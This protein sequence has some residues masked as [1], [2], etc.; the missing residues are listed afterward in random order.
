MWKI[1]TFCLHL[2]LFGSILKVYF[3]STLVSGLHPQLTLREQGLEPPADRIVVF[4]VDGLRA[5][6]FFAKNCTYFPH[7][8]KLFVEQGLVGVAHVALP[9]RTRPGHL[10]LFGGFYEDHSQVLIKFKEAPGSFDTVFNRSHSAYGWSCDFVTNFLSNSLNGGS[11][12]NFESHNFWEFQLGGR[13]NWTVTKVRSFFNNIEKVKQ[14]QNEKSVVFYA[15]FGDTDMAGHHHN[16]SFLE[17]LGMTDTGISDIYEIFERMFP[18]GRTSYLM[19]SDHGMTD[20]GSH[21]DSSPDEAQVPFFFWGSGIKRE[22]HNVGQKFVANSD[23]LELPLHFLDQRELAPLMSALIGLPPPMNNQAVLPLGYMNVSLKYEAY[24]AYLNALQ[25]LSQVERIMDNHH[26][27]I[28]ND[29]L[30]TFPHLD[31]KRIKRYRELSEQSLKTGCYVETM[32]KS[33]TMARVAVDCLKYYYNFYRRPLIVAIVCSYLGWFYH[34]LAMQARVCVGIKKRGFKSL[35]ILLLSIGSLIVAGFIFLARIPYLTA[36][37]LLLPFIVWILALRERGSHTGVCVAPFLQML[38]IGGSAAMIVSTIYESRLISLWYVLVV[39]VPN[40]KSFRRP[41]IKLLTWLLLVGI[42]SMFPVLISSLGTADDRLLYFGMLLVLLR[43]LVLGQRHDWYVW[44]INTAV[45]L[46]GAYGVYLHSHNETIY[47]GMHVIAWTYLCFVFLCIPYS[48]SSGPGSRVDLIFFSLSTLY[49]LLCLS[50][51]LIFLQ[52]LVTEYLV[53]L[54]LHAD[55]KEGKQVV[56]DELEEERE[57]NKLAKLTAKDHIRIAYRH[58][59]TVLIYVFFS[60]YGTGNLFS[61]SSFEPK[62][63]RMFLRDFTL[64]SSIFLIILKLFIP[65]IILLACIQAFSAYARQY[66]KLVLISMLLI[67]D[68]IIIYMFFT[69]ENQGPLLTIL[70]SV[71]NLKILHSNPLLLI[72]MFYV[73]KWLLSVKPLSSLIKW[74]AAIPDNIGTTQA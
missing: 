63:A 37:Y 12:L 45:L 66:S 18:D 24:A 56:D 25:L 9:P 3:N 13:T 62:S 67:S 52:L 7:L 34:L 2:L 30:S 39:C 46:M 10:A 15:Y 11:P 48:N 59:S 4:L 72:M 70:R 54:S 20:W 41:S 19:T 68:V 8:Q 22:A 44:L 32:A 61:M 51:E 69:V 40:M 50:S 23:G 14:L 58:A 17:V 26:G 43:P 42:L 29:L 36:L 35:P 74:E 65:I 49:S 55:S 27:G 31:A 73:A 60:F 6:S 47:Y 33:Q 53:G 57:G 16:E 64:H 5:K 28:F 21:E 38:W 1:Y 71:N